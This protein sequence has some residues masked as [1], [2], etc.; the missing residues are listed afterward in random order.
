[1]DDSVDFHRFRRQIDDTRARNFFPPLSVSGRVDNGNCRRHFH[2]LDD[3]CFPDHCHHPEVEERYT[4]VV[5]DRSGLTSHS[6][7]LS[8]SHRRHL[9]HTAVVFVTPLSSNHD[10]SSREE[11]ESVWIL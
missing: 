4:I 8:S 1:M 9:H 6:L 10:E 11:I 3:F 5:V 7:P 2:R